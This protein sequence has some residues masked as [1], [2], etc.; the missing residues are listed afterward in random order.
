MVSFI[1]HQHSLKMRKRNRRKR[2]ATLTDRLLNVRKH[3]CYSI[4][5]THT[6]TLLISMFTSSS[7]FLH[8]SL[9]S[10]DVFHLNII[11]MLS[12]FN[13]PEYKRGFFW[14]PGQSAIRKEGSSTA[15]HHRAPPVTNRL[16][17]SARCPAVRGKKGIWLDVALGT[18]C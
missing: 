10:A 5:F 7:T 16:Q 3:L 12:C 1:K 18:H 8:K 14:G 15:C 13:C 17:C 11:I 6:H 4:T 9:M 2:R